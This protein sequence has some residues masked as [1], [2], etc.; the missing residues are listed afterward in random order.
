MQPRVPLDWVDALCALV[1]AVVAAG[2]L[3]L[4]VGFV[5]D[6][7][8]TLSLAHFDGAL[9]AAGSDQLAARPVGSLVYAVV[10]GGVGDA[11]APTIVALAGL[12]VAAALLLRRLLHVV[13]P[14]D[15]A[16]AAAVLWVAL[17]TTTSLEVWP[18]ASN[19]AVALVAAL[20][21]CRL[22]L[23]GQR[24]ITFVGVAVLA[25]VAVLSYEAL[26][27][28]L[29]MVAVGALAW[30]PLRSARRGAVAVLVGAGGALAW[31]VTHWHPAKDV[32]EGWGEMDNLLPA[33]LG[34]G[35]APPAV[36]PFVAATVVIVSLVA[37]VRRWQVAPVVVGWAVLV[38]GAVPFVKYTYRPL[39]AGD[40]LLVVSSLG[41]A[42][43]L[44]AACALAGRARHVA[45]VVVLALAVAPRV[46]QM[47]SWAAS[48][49]DARAVLAAA[50][51]V[52]ATPGEIVLGP[53]TVVRNGTAGFQDPTIFEEGVRLRLDDEG[54]EATLLFNAA[55]F[56]AAPPPKI[57]IYEVVDDPS[58]PGSRL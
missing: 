40:R 27:A 17:P 14:A 36:G 12:R 41:G 16:A 13:V 52:A 48:A 28:L 23:T 25:A 4:D 29:G 3:L 19:I 33:T 7:W 51:A 21:A 11:I 44:A 20:L 30:P 49:D 46:V 10:F 1:A 50:E 54:R 2:Y 35:I 22:A 8:F 15:V 18:S 56:D 34:W 37:L 6:D 26:V 43:L 31:S 5:M 53:G 45:L 42:L 38:G 32:G 55:D 57:D 47:R 39:G 9:R 58:S 24:R